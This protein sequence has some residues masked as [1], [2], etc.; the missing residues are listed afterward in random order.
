MFGP[1]KTYQRRTVV[2]PAFLRDL[3][4][5][6]LAVEV[7]P[8]EDTLVFTSPGGEPWRRGNF[9]RRVWRPALEAAG[10]EHLRVHDLR[11]TC[12]ALLIA[13]GAHPKVV[14]A[15]LGHSSIQVTM[16]RYGHLF[17]SDAEDLAERLDTTRTRTLT[18]ARRTV[19][20]SKVVELPTR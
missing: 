1:T 5:H 3:V 14:Q 20:P 12:A 7:E 17:P 8:G 4:A 18:G 19:G 6:H 16:D 15:H 10:M 2:V 13:E 11:H 9:N